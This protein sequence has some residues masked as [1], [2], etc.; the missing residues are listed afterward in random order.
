MKMADKDP[1]D[2][3]FA[4]AREDAPVPSD[5]LLARIAADADQV[6]E[7][8]RPAARPAR[9]TILS[10]LGGWR[11]GAGLA[12][13]ALTGLVIGY[14]APTAVTGYVPGVTGDDYDLSDLGAGYGIDAFE[15]E[16][17]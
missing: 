10:L 14:V 2:D 12:A 7:T 13:A 16:Q 8:W 17:G 9:P 1:M 4:A 3:F 6:A 11:G 15:E 5:A